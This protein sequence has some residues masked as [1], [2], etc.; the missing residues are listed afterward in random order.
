MLSQSRTNDYN[1]TQWYFHLFPHFSRIQ[2]NGISILPTCAVE[3]VV[4]PLPVKTGIFHFLS[5]IV[6]WSYIVC[7]K[8]L[9]YCFPEIAKA[10]YPRDWPLCLLLKY[11]VILKY[12]LVCRNVSFCYNW[13]RVLIV[14][15]FYCF[16]L[17]FLLKK[18]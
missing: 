15:H 11:F 12:N 2:S 5:E 13:V 8:G 18:Y 9:L 10:Q 14:S 4:F 6:V 7:N 1:L 17:L 16:C 3:T